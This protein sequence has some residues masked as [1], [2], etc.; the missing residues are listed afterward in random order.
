MKNANGV[1]SF[2]RMPKVIDILNNL[3]S[4]HNFYKF[5]DELSFKVNAVRAVNMTPEQK[6]GMCNVNVEGYYIL[7]M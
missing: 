7:D 2:D 3:L 6:H 1:K 5:L 4:N